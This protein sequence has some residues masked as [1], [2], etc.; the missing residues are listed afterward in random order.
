LIV[1]A[2]QTTATWSEGFI[3]EQD[4]E[5]IHSMV[6]SIINEITARATPGTPLSALMEEV[7]LIDFFH[8]WQ[9]WA[10]KLSQ[11]ITTFKTEAFPQ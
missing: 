1:W 7:V 4:E 5:C 11:L 3:N 10:W 2:G 9:G 8:G 6:V